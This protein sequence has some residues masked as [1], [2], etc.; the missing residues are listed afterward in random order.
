MK[1]RVGSSGWPM[2][3]ALVRLG[4]IPLAAGA[5]RLPD[6][7]GGAP[8]HTGQGP[9]LCVAP[10]SGA[11]YRRRCRAHRPACI[12]FRARHPPPE[13]RLASSSRQA[14][15]R[16]WTHRY[17]V[18]TVDDAVLAAPGPRWRAAVWLPAAV[19]FAH[20]HLDRPRRRR[21]QARRD[22]PSSGLEDARLRPRTGRG[23]AGT[24][25]RI[26]RGRLRP[27]G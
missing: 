20:G 26:R 23:H 19:R 12:P 8:I 16:I 10:A 2:T 22:R 25:P 13:P 4:A 17:G 6:L 21:D 14:A 27:A 7:A 24:Y 9:L 18:G 5:F 3:A 11:A 1:T 15:G